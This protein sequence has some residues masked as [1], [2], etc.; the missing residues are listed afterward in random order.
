MAFFDSLSFLSRLSKRKADMLGQLD[1]ANKVSAVI[2][3]MSNRKK[4]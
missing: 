1:A 4:K 2:E 3:R